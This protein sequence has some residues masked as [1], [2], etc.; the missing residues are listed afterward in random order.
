M[1]NSLLILK[2]DFCLL[3]YKIGITGGI[4]S[5]KST[6][7]KVVAEF[8]HIKAIDMDIIARKLFRINKQILKDIQ[9]EFG[10]D[11]VEIDQYGM[12][13][14]KR[15]LLGS[16]VFEN[17]N[18]LQTLNSI[19]IPHIIKFLN[20]E[21]ERTIKD[22][23]EIDIVFIEGAILIES[24]LSPLFNEIWLTKFDK[25]KAL[26]RIIQRD[27]LSIIEA[28]NRLKSQINDNERIK[29][30][31]FSY[32]SNDPLEKNRKLIEEQLRRLTVEKKL[33]KFMKK[34]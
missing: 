7:R 22:E 28:K 23:K 29:F 1:H 25:E 19:A 33:R 27:K 6:L 5:G 20:L 21:F 12:P 31:S 24:N 11:I 30:C 9:N 32:D 14:L 26:E 18:K 17:P 15:R 3:M 4:A 34:S 8:L 13:N 16:I 10:Q 2:L